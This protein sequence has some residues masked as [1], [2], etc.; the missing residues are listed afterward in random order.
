MTVQLIRRTAKELAGAFYEQG[1]RSD[2]FR[3]AFPTVQDFLAGRAHRKDGTIEM[4]DPNWWQFVDLAKQT[5]VQMLTDKSIHENL[6]TPIYE[7]LLEEAARGS[8]PNT[9]V[10]AQSNLD[11]REDQSAW[12]H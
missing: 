2:M 5:L 4:Q 7:A 1:V 8:K 10:V 12:V 3:R 9:K 11:K 6:K